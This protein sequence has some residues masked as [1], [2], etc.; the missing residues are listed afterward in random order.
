MLR[1]G[2]LSEFMYIHPENHII[3]DID[4]PIILQGVMSKGSVKIGNNCW[5]G[6]RAT[7]LDG[8]SIGSGCVVAAGPVVK[9]TFPDNSIIGDFPAKI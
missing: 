2:T 7:I 9:V 8:T 4:T 3:E 5:I 1:L 6:T